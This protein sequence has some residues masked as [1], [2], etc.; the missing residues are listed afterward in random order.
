MPQKKFEKFF[1][2]SFESEE[3]R[4]QFYNSTKFVAS[5]ELDSVFS[6]F[7]NLEKE[8][9]ILLVRSLS[10]EEIP[11]SMKLLDPNENPNVL[12]K[13]LEKITFFKGKDRLSQLF[14]IFKIEKLQNKTLQIIKQWKSEETDWL[15][16]EK[17]NSKDKKNKI[18]ALYLI[19]ILRKKQ[20]KEKVKLYI[21]SKNL[22]VS[23]EAKET[24]RRL[25]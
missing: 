19:G 1:L 17:L 10:T 2:N 18:F 6:V 13:I 5:K 8:E 4:L 14:E 20:F 15:L 16:E 21:K 23:Y 3:F 25:K 22:L 12:R 7:K 24:L 11:L 9:K